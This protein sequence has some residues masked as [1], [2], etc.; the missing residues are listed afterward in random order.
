MIYVYFLGKCDPSKCKRQSFGFKFFIVDLSAHQT[1]HKAQHLESLF[2]NSA[3]NKQRTKRAAPIEGF[4]M[5]GNNEAISDA[6]PVVRSCAQELT[7]MRKIRGGLAS[8][9]MKLQGELDILM[10]DVSSYKAAAKT[11][12][13]YDEAFAKCFQYCEEYV[14]IMPCGDFNAR[15]FSWDS[16]GVNPNGRGLAEALLDLDLHLLNTGEPTR[17]AERPGDTD[18]C[19]VLTLYSSDLISRLIWKFGSHVDTGQRSSTV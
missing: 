15:H 6:C 12:N 8:Q 16:A 9:V 7:K 1:G 3:E 4:H 19:M 2:L 10:L 18:S 14:S 5:E 17:L 13:A 11:K